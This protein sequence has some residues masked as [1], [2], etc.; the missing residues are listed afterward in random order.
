MIV[1][2]LMSASVV[3]KL[4]MPFQRTDNMTWNNGLK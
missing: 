3:S 1:T 4:S 2:S